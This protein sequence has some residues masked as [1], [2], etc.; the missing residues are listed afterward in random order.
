MKSCLLPVHVNLPSAS[1]PHECQLLA[2]AVRMLLEAKADVNA[3]C[4][5]GIA[6]LHGAAKNGHTEAVRMLLEAG[7]DE[8]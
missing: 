2:E 6:A 7:A 4:H 8:Q 3:T 5:D 1:V